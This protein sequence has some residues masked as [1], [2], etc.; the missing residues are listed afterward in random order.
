MAG[1]R[2]ICTPTSALRQLSKCRAPR[3]CRQLHRRY[4]AIAPVAALAR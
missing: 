4:Q 2:I 3:I 1:A